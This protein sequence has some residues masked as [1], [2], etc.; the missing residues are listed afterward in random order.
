MNELREPNVAFYF[1]LDYQKR[2]LVQIASYFS[3]S[4]ISNDL[5]QIKK[6]E[7]DFIITSDYACEIIKDYF[8]GS[9]VNI[10]AL[11]HGAVNKYSQPESDFNKADYIFGTEFEKKYLESGNVKPIKEFLLTGNPWVDETFKIRKK[12]IDKNNPTIL[13][14]PTYN[15]EISAAFPLHN[16]LYKLIK[17]V[18]N[19]FT[20]IIKPH[21]AI[22]NSDFGHTFK[23]KKIF[24]DWLNYWR[25]I[26]QE[27]NN[28]RII[29]DTQTSISD[30]FYETDLLI[31]DRSSLIWE[32]IIL[33]KPILLFNTNDKPEF[34]SDIQT[35]FSIDNFID[36]GASFGNENEFSIA[37]KDIFDLQERIFQIKQK[38][39]INKIFGIYQDGQSCKRAAEAIKKIFIKTDDELFINAKKLFDSN[40]YLKS[41]ELFALLEDNPNYCRESSKYLEI[42]QSIADKQNYNKTEVICYLEQPQKGDSIAKGD[43]ISGWCLSKYAECT[44]IL[45]LLNNKIQNVRRVHRKDVSDVYPEF[46]TNNP[47]PGFYFDVE[48]KY[49]NNGKNIVK[50]FMGY[51][52]T[53]LKILEYD[54]NS[55]TKVDQEKVPQFINDKNNIHSN[56]EVQEQEL[57]FENNLQKHFSSSIDKIISIGKTD[58]KNILLDSNYSYDILIPIYNAYDQVKICVESVLRNTAQ[59]HKVYLLDDAS[60]D[61]RILPLLK[62]FAQKDK[63]VVVLSSEKNLGFIGNMNRGFVLS[64]NDV[65]IL[66]SDTQVT[67]LWVEKM[68]ACVSSKLNAGIVSPLSNNATIL[69][70]PEMNASNK[71]PKNFSVDDLAKL[72]DRVSLRVYPEIPTAVGFCMLI[73]RKVLNE[74]GFFD[75]VF[76][77]G[78]GEENDLCERAKVKGF[79]ILCCDDAYVH[80]YGEASFSFVDKIDERRKHNQ[81]ILDERWPNYNSEVFA[82]CRLN[83]LREIQE[84]VFHAI[85]NSGKTNILHVMHNFNVAG[86]T[87]LHTSNLVNGLADEFDSTVIYPAP[88]GYLYTDAVSKKLSKHLREVKFAKEN[89]LSVEHFGGL[90]ADL[91]SNLIEENFTRFLKG[92]NYNIVHFQHLSGWSTFLLPLI[93]KRME[94]KV[95]ISLHDF[96]LL[97]PELNLIY[98]YTNQRCNKRIADPNDKSCIYCLGTKRYNRHPEKAVALEE[99]LLERNYLIKKVIESADLLIVP[100]NFVK[101]KF[102]SAFGY[103][104]KEKILVVPHGITELMKIARPKISKKLRVG[105]L[106]NATVR[107]GI[108]VFLEAVKKLQSQDFEFEVFGNASTEIK[109]KCTELKIKVNGGYKTEQLPKLLHNVDLVLIASIVDETFSLT[110]SEALSMGIPVLS[111]DAGALKERIE[112]G[113]TGFLF[114]TGD[115][116]N[117]VEKLLF[118]KDN[119]QLLKEVQITISNQKVKTTEENIED[120]RQI[121][122]KLISNHSEVYNIPKSS[123]QFTQLTSIIVLTYNALT[124]T[125]IFYDSLNLFGKSNYELIFVDNAST[126]GTKEYLDA[127]LKSNPNVKVIFNEKNLGFPIAVNQGIK[128]ANGKYILIANNDIVVTEGWLER[129][130]EA[131]ESDNRIGIVGPISNE[132]SGLQKDKEANY[133]T[134]DE[135]HLYATAVKGKNKNKV[136]QFPRVAFLCTLIKK[137]V[138]DKIGG[139]DERFTPGNYEDDD[140]CLRAQLAGFKTIIAQDVF[141]HHYGSKSFKANGEH[142]YAER[143]KINRQI[144]VDKWGADP[145]EIWLKQKPFNHSRSLYI[146]IDNDEFKNSFERAQ[147]NIRDKEFSIATKELELAIEKYDSSEKARSIISKEELLLLSAN[148]FLVIKDLEKANML[149]EAALKLNP[150]SSEAC[151]GLGQVFYQAEMYEQSKTMFEWAVKNNPQNLSALEALKTVN[152]NLSLPESHNSLIEVEVSQIEYGS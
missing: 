43:R 128:I 109:T 55:D 35:E 51:Q 41:Y 59:Q 69:S 52:N 37:L 137:E 92:G 139:L 115:S 89:N 100:S 123:E 86:G 8:S 140:F 10:A 74:V 30:F 23:H 77:L 3:N 60:P 119:Y 116:D 26:S 148:V 135:M 142:K 99:Y 85:N 38:E 101:E 93:A 42:I 87:E 64:E 56:F 54:F 110:L 20:L 104:I 53:I 28:V 75:P 125:R 132:V 12:F 105:F 84:R 134:I 61:N 138:I 107:K 91:Y 67:P 2:A 114:R 6:F 151:F 34:W 117:L 97:C 130:I 141:I 16:K 103:S 118:I 25:Q 70:V 108:Y 19:E 133:K 152:L 71:L 33:Q 96:Y 29:E 106:G 68:H 145:D 80:H 78:Y 112:D 48:E 21:P 24:Q 143:L 79:K 46:S 13:F 66:N 129:L 5:L 72:V 127:I 9:N 7:P 17:E 62:E 27:F 102:L 50:I 39:Y 14:A 88:L 11:R 1:S 147:T 63:R 4:L 44:D 57:I 124:Y 58:S 95:I 65:I 126:D 40:N 120:Y 31:S 36:V 90:P 76:G 122:H 81:K 83:P 15:P 22:L 113:K 73:K 149:F 150:S 45:I 121:Y 82:F 146:S 111:S 144:F 18:F 94:K 136:I 32:F 47:N 98:S 131:A 49:L